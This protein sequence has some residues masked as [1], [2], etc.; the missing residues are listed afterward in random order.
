MKLRFEKGGA[1]VGIIYVL[2]E[3]GRLS[4]EDIVRHTGFE[5]TFVAGLLDEAN[6]NGWVKKKAGPNGSDNWE[7]DLYGIPAT[8]CLMVMSAAEKP[9]DAL[10]ALY[11]LHGSYDKGYLVFPYPVDDGFLKKCSD[12]K[13]GVMVFDQKPL[14]S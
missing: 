5:R 12:Q 11:E 10:K 14:P 3:N 6:G 1:P 8:E 13:T 9:S 4:T 2:M 7:L